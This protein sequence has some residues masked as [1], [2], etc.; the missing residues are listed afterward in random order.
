M[1]KVYNLL[2]KAL[3]SLGVAVLIAAWISASCQNTFANGL[4]IDQQD[5]AKC[6]MPN[7]IV[8]QNND[9]INPTDCN[10]DTKD[11]GCDQ[12]DTLCICRFSMVQLDCTCGY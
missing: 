6:S 11:A 9:I 2:S 10:K 12:E 5:T 8:C 3:G 1:G 4:G 7:Q